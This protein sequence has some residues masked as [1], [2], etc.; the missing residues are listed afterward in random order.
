[1]RGREGNKPSCERI[2][3]MLQGQGHEE[4]IGSFLCYSGD[5]LQ[6]QCLSVLKR[7]VNSVL[8]ARTYYVIDIIK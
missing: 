4:N 6:E 8:V 3:P 2:E 1:M 5:S 7:D